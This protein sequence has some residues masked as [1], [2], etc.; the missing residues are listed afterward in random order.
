MNDSHA[1]QERWLKMYYL[2]RAVFSV[3]WV[4]AAV[5]AARHAPALAAALLV[6]YPAWDA[7]AN[8]VDG[9]RNGGL[10]ANRTQA[11]NVAASLIV[12]VGVAIALPDQNRVLAVFGAWAIV[13]GLLQLGTGLRRWK[14]YGAQWAMILSGAQSALA[15]AAFIVQA[16]TSA[17]PA[18][19]TVAGYA[20]FGAFY[21]L[22]SALSLQA[23]A[24]RR[25][26]AVGA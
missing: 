22:V 12:A 23:A 17:V 15:G 13:S 26:R 1:A 9:A 18:L 24:W 7:L 20:G 2:T 16:R 11:V 14:A 3:A 10:A 21:F 19:A 4:A 6:A 8:L 5:G 25:R